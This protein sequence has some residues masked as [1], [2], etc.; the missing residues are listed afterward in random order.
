MIGPKDGVTTE[1]PIETMSN[2]KNDSEF[3]AAFS[4]ATIH[5]VRSIYR[6]KLQNVPTNRKAVDPEPPPFL[7]IYR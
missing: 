1:R 6:R 3:L 2:K 4:A 5:N 7:L